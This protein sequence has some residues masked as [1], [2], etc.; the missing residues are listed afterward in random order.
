MGS[1]VKVKT[2]NSLLFQ[3]PVPDSFW[4][5]SNVPLGGRVIDTQLWM[6][7]DG[8][9]LHLPISV[10]TVLC[11]NAEKNKG[12]KNKGSILS[13]L[14]PKVTK[15]LINISRYWALNN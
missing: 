6:P 8:F 14:N 1:V 9:R 2:K 10:Q 3:V 11:G 13:H 15:V 12:E 4:V 7:G 5:V